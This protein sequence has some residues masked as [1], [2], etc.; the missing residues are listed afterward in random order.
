[1]ELSIVQNTPNDFIMTRIWDE[2]L[3]LFLRN[4]VLESTKFWLFG[5][6]SGSRIL[7]RRNRRIILILCAPGRSNTRIFIGVGLNIMSLQVLF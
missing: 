6:V 5:F 4:C 2:V 7:G 1:M 3:H